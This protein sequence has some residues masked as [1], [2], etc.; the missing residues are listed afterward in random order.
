MLGQF[1]LGGVQNLGDVPQ[2]AR[3]FLE[4]VQRAFAGDSF[5]AAHAG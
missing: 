4:L 3:G 5:D 2:R 1:G